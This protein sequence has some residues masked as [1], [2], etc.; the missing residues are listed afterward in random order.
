MIVLSSTAQ[1]KTQTYDIAVSRINVGTLVASKVVEGNTTTYSL[2]SKSSVHVFV[3]TTIITS[4]IAV[5]K[6]GILESCTYTS[7]KNGSPYDSSMITQNNGVYTIDK[8]GNKS[9][10]SSPIKNITAMLYFEKPEAGTIFFDVLSG[11]YA[12]IEIIT[13]DTF[14]FESPGSSEKTIYTYKN[15]ILEKGVTNYAFYS[16]TY[17]AK[18]NT[19]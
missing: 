7:E 1:N 2:T 14:S 17:T 15:N 11:T 18:N 16:F 4:M 10:Y 19:N 13:Q 3:Q 8:K 5:F 9:T 6:N 12:P